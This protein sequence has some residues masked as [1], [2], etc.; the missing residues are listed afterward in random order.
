MGLHQA[1]TLTCAKST[2]LAHDAMSFCAVAADNGSAPTSASEDKVGPLSG[3]D[4]I[5]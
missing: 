5:A 2:I 3:G 4:E 1:C